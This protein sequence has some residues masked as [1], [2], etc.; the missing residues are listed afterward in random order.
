M[1][2]PFA[3]ACLPGSALRALPDGQ[4]Y[5]LEQLSESA[6]WRARDEVHPEAAANGRE[7]SRALY[8][9]LSHTSECGDGKNLQYIAAH[10]IIVERAGT[11]K[12]GYQRV[13]CIMN[14]IRALSD[15]YRAL[16][17][18]P[19]KPRESKQELYLPDKRGYSCN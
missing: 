7:V 1:P 18:A 12:A 2:H 15:E 6:V 13:R 11:N 19:K 4:I 8:N 14:Q 16:I 10:P 9:Q 5:L 3:L 17:D